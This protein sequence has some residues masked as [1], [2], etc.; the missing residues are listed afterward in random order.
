MEDCLKENESKTKSRPKTES[1]FDSM[2]RNRAIRS[3]DGANPLSA[4]VTLP[5][6]VTGLV[7]HS[8]RSRM[9][10]WKICKQ[11]YDFYLGNR[12]SAEIL[13]SISIAE[14]E[15]PPG[16]VLNRLLGLKTGRLIWVWNTNGFRSVYSVLVILYLWNLADIHQPTAYN[17]AATIIEPNNIGK[18][19]V[20][21]SSIF[22]N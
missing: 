18:V 16:K 17:F 2:H 15:V 5:S 20:S 9:G 22:L 8:R 4:V 19:W 7:G 11:L 1:H 12:N 6:F 3:K 13:G 21:I 10:F 14:M